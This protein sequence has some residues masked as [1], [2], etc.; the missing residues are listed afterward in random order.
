MGEPLADLDGGAGFVAELW[1]WEGDAAWHFVTLPPELSDAIEFRTAARDR[2]RGFGSVRVEVTVGAT[3]W[4]TSLFPD[5]GRGAYV[6]PVKRAVRDA[7]GLE[8]GAP[9]DVRLSLVDD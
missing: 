7:E 9:V 1:L 8:L 4:R 2:Q 6:L 5:S 3:T